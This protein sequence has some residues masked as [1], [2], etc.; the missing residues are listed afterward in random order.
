MNPPPLNVHIP[1]SKTYFSWMVR[2]L[3]QIIFLPL[4]IFLLGAAISGAGAWWLYNEIEDNAKVEFQRNVDRV[5]GE[6]VWRFSQPIYGLNGIK[7]AYAANGYLTRQQFRAY[8]A[9]RNLPVEFPGVRGQGFVQRVPR[10]QLNEFIANARTDGAPEF[11]LRQLQDKQHDDLYI[12]KYIEPA[13]KNQGAEGLDI[14]SES[15]RREAVLL[16]INSGKPTLSGAIHLVQSN[17]KTPGIL[18]FVPVYKSGTNPTTPAERQASLVGLLYSPIVIAD[19][20]RDIPEFMNGQVDVELFDSQNDL[21]NKTMVFDADGSKY[22]NA[23]PDQAYSDEAIAA[24][25]FHNTRVLPLPGREMTLRVSSTPAFEVLSERYAPWLVFAFG[26]LLSSALA[27]LIRQQASGRN[28][29]EM[30]ARNMTA[31]LERLALVAKNTSNAVIIT[32]VNREIVWVNEGF[33]R[34]TGYS[35]T[36]VSGKS[37][38]KLLQ[39]SSTDKN[40]IKAMKAALDAG[41]PFKGEIVNRSKLGQ[42]YWIELEIQPRYNDQNEPIGFMAIESDISERKATYQRLETALRENNA[43]LTTLNLHG[44]ISTADSAGLVTDVNDAFCHIS[45]YSREELIGQ[46]YRLVDSHTHDSAFWQSMWHNIA[47]GVSWRGEICN[48]AK[49]GH[50]YWVDTTIA[51]FKN[52]TGQI[53]RYI[54]IQI[55]ITASKIQQTNLL[56]A[57]NQ[58]VRAADVAELGIWTW[59]IPEGTF[60]FD[61]RMNDIY[62]LPE[63][64][65]NT[66]LPL[67]YWYSLLHPDDLLNV[68]NTIKIA[69]DNGS[70]YR[71]IFRIIVH[72]QVRYIQSTGTVE[73]DEQGDAVLMMGINRD[74]TQQREA[75]NILQTARDAAEEANKAKSAFLANM[76]HELRTPMNAILGMLTLLRKT[77]LNNKQA[78]YAVKSEAA[79]RTLLRLLN[80]ILDFSKI[81][82]GKMELEC[83]PFDIHVMLRDLAVILSS[84]LKIKKVEVLF[85]IDPALPQFVEGD[86]MRLQ[87]ILTNLGGNA[88]KFTEQ[89][90]VVLFIKVLKQ[91]SHQVTLHFGVRDTGIG[92]APEHQE[93]IFSGFTQA[94]AST[95]RRFGGTGL[96]LVISQ[97]FVALMGGTLELESQPGQGSLFHFTITLSLSSSVNLTTNNETPGTLAGRAQEL[98]HLRVLVVDDNPTAGE[99]IKRMGESL[100]WTVDV[101]TSGEQALELMKQQRDSG[102]TYGA[103]FIDWQM[104][105]LDGWQTSKYV[106]ELMPADNTPMIVMITAHD[107]E[108]LLQRSEEDQALLDGYLVKPITASM[109]LDSVI[110]AL[111]ERKQPDVAKPR[112]AESSNQLSGIRLLIVE[113][114]LNNQQIA[115]ELLEDEGATVTIANHGKE[116]IDILEKTPTL[117][118]L[119]LM[120]LQMPVMDGFNATQ[121]IRRTLGLKELPIIAMTANAMIS[122]RDACLA[123]GMNDHIGKPFDLNNLIQTIRK[124]SGHT[125]T[126]VSVSRVSPSS[127]PAELKNIATTTGIE[128]ESALNRLGG[129]VSLYQKMLSLFAADLA[130]LP[131]QLDELMK[132]GD[133]HSASRLLHT[134]KG[135][136]AQLGA[137]ELS[138][139][140]GQGERLLNNSVTATVEMINQLLSDLQHIVSVIQVDIAALIQLLSADA[141]PAG[142]AETLNTHAIEPELHSL[143]ALLENSDMAALEVI[144]RLQ[145]TFGQQLNKQ[146]LPLNQAINQ[147]DFAKAIQLCKTLLVNLSRQRDKKT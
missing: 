140:A 141:E 17:V 5:S 95:T 131:A 47:N 116:A 55:D 75:E 70:I 127:L 81:E 23:I 6:I 88:L 11:A 106:R 35:Q 103:L 94:E 10:S 15:V 63:E 72:G 98:N 147:L 32:D 3:Q 125:D 64:M 85:D 57:R 96:G 86:S 108:M 56:I 25:I 119:V 143:I 146:L 13:E 144:S 142:S 12:I 59:N 42:E 46:S 111:N 113:D 109:L 105:G 4:L 132:Q 21:S 136:S 93:S 89:G 139:C 1:T 37:P 41:E 91:D 145:I 28:R 43:L 9:S 110:D 20:L 24:R 39:C 73:H 137:T 45:G 51:P 102:I 31:D 112:M 76:S 53:E 83:I 126:T 27:L 29:A 90:E 18:L 2:L 135:L 62:A 87:Q 82:S 78:D 120:D 68:Q 104:P 100:K 58:L 107:R 50:L 44:I 71:Q 69:L 60:S 49:S 133:H 122:D 61:D 80:D 34:I 129:D 8:V 97:R 77:G 99:L 48:K 36:E 74:I 19:L 134:I 66:P 54:S 84:N 124:Y 16:A 114:N 38:G 52:N 121:Y 79:T 130:T 40:V 26:L 7:A 138:L 118:D 128:V 14:G 117:F 22:A 123:A 101:A 115:R 92:I 65:R 67:E 30:L 33:E